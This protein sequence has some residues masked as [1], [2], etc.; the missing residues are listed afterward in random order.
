MHTQERKHPHSRD[1][2]MRRTALRAFWASLLENDDGRSVV[3]CHRQCGHLL[4]LEGRHGAKCMLRYVWLC[5]VLLCY[6]LIC[7]VM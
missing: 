3:N 6:L 7:D 4:F 2:N 1:V 5:S